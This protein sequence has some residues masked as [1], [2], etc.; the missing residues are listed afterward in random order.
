MSLQKKKTVAPIYAAEP[1]SLWYARESLAPIRK[2]FRDKNWL[3]VHRSMVKKAMRSE[4][5]DAAWFRGW[6]DHG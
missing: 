1:L 4:Q 6:G 5:V 3:D 2:P